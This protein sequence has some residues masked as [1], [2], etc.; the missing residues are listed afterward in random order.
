MELLAF[1]KESSLGNL[2]FPQI[3]LRASSLGNCWHSPRELKALP[4]ELFAFL[5]ENFQS[6]PRRQLK[7]FFK[8][9]LAF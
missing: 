4:K 7:G 1:F 3:E 8:E 6:I 5:G 9:L 2:G